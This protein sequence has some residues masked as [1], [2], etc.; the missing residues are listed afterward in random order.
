M[1]AADNELTAQQK[2]KVIGVG[3]NKTATKSLAHCLKSMGYQNQ[4]YS[5]DAFA[6]YQESNWPALFALMDSHDSFEDWPWPL[7][8][9]EIDQQY[10]D[11]RFILTTRKSPQS[12]YRSLCKMAVRMGPLNDFEKYIYGHAMPQA[13]PEAHIAFYEAHNSEV[14]AYFSDRPEKLMEICFDN[15]V[16]FPALC[17]FLDEPVVA[18]SKPHVNRSAKVY[19]GESL[20]LAHL[21][22]VVFQAYWHS[23]QWLRQAKHRLDKRT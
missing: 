23:R 15:D 5:I 13:A 17:V 19:G 10:P 4:S 12:W 11:A 8:F 14:R 22:R 18:F 2:H 21:N 1:S 6:L 16:D 7:M 20:W 3:L 9:K